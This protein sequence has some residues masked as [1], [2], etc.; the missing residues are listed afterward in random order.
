MQDSGAMPGFASL[1]GAWCF[2]RLGRFPVPQQ[3]RGEFVQCG[4]PAT[5][6][7]STSV[8]HAIGLASLSLAVAIS[9]A[10]IAECRPPLSTPANNAFLRP[11]ASG[12]WRPRR[13]W[14]LAPRA[15]HRD[16]GS[17]R[18]SDPGRSVSPKWTAGNVVAGQPGAHRLD[19]WPAARTDRRFSAGVTRMSAS[20][21]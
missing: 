19:Q 20:M 6:R 15:H 5:M 16:R 9:A 12:V 17:A 4:R 13:W 18:S 14:Y 8:S 3:Q 11:R 7:C 21:A 1:P 10:M 2:K